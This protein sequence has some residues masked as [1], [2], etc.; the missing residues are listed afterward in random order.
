[1]K[2]A[3]PF[4]VTTLII[5]TPLSLHAGQRLWSQYAGGLGG[6]QYSDLAQINTSNVRRLELAWQ[7]RSGALERRNKIENATAK[8]QVNPILLPEAAGGHLVICTPFNRIIA[9]DPATGE[10]R[11]VFDSE[12]RIGGYATA[13]DP[14]GLKSAPFPNCRGVAYWHDRSESDSS[15]SCQHRIMMATHDLRLVAVDARNGGVCAEFGDAGVVDVEP[16]VLNAQPPAAAGEV[17]FPS[18]PLIVNDVIVV[19]S[20]VRDNHRFND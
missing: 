8:V 17:K 19:G 7:Y 18:P 15:L 6:Q 14:E 4:L 2:R 20:S 3:L 9:L 10:E 16:T 1:M 11:W 5:L 12:S 13:D